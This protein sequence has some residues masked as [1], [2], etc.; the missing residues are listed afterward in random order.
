MKISLNGGIIIIGSLYW[1]DNIQR[2]DWRNESLN[3]GNQILVKV[4]IRYGRISKER[5]NTFSMV[6]SYECKNADLLGNAIFA[7]F[8]KNPLDYENLEV[9]M[10]EIIKSE[11]K[12]KVLKNSYNNWL[13]GTLGILINP[14][15]K[16][17]D[18]ISFLLSKWKDKYSEKFSYYDY[19]IGEEPT[20]I[21]KSGVFQFHW[22][23]NLD[24]FDFII[25]TA[26]KPESEKYPGHQEIIDKMLTSGYTEYYLKNIQNGITTFQDEQI[27]QKIK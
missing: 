7:P 25:A 18:E 15:S 16:K 3:L 6:F 27:S 2:V 10:G 11:Q 17:F 5:K 1:D 14:K 12:R 4:P 19:K 8:K 22:P 26:T 9:E 23:E 13:W 21:N 20:I 24:D